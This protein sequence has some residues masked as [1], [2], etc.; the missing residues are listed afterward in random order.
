MSTSMINKRRKVRALEAKR[1]QLM[2]KR[3]S[4][5][6]E[7]LKVRAELKGARKTK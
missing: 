6:T 2:E 5:K 7:L 3:D 4:S 1:D